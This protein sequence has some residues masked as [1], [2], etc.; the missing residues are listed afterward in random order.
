[1]CVCVGWG[2]R[3]NL[4]AK[5]C[6]TLVTLWNAALQPP[7]AVGFSRQEYWS[8]CHFLLPGISPTQG[9]NLGLLHFRQILY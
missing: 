3:D 8:G 5:S 1:M 2:G 7:L 6:L 4:V 9:S